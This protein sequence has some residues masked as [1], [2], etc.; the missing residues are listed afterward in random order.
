MFAPIFA[1]NVNEKKITWSGLEREAFHQSTFVRPQNQ[2]K[3]P[4]RN[5][6]VTLTEK[7]IPAKKNNHALSNHSEIILFPVPD[8]DWPEGGC[9]LFPESRNRTEPLWLRP[10]D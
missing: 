2:E 6:I 4:G 7:N 8:D 10:R 3:W 9:L 1:L 5:E